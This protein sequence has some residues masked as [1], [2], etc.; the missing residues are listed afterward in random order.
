MQSEKGAVFR[1][2]EYLLSDAEL[3]DQGLV[4]PLCTCVLV[5][6]VD[7]PCC[8]Q[9]FCEVC[10][11]QL[12][13]TCPLCRATLHGMSVPSS[14]VVQQV[15]DKLKLQCPG[16][17]KKQL[18]RSQL[19][20]HLAAE[21][22]GARVSR[23]REEKLRCAGAPVCDA[24]FDSEADKRAHERRCVAAYV[25]G[26]V[27]ELRERC[28]RLEDT[29]RRL[30]LICREM[31]N[32]NSYTTTSEN[33]SRAVCALPMGSHSVLLG[34]DSGLWQVD[35]RTGEFVQKD[36]KLR[37]VRVI[38]QTGRTLHVVSRDGWC[39]LDAS[40]AQWGA[41]CPPPVLAKEPIL[42]RTLVA[43]ASLDQTYAFVLTETGEAFY[44]MNN[45]VKLLNTMWAEKAPRMMV[46][47]AEG[48]FV[49][50]VPQVG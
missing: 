6:P 46:A 35:C 24:V 40:A 26:E 44:F 4:C 31:R 16:G 34:L 8:R 18:D 10:F 17:C 5:E 43:A 48:E 14:R 1:T 13:G 27:G 15:L 19:L 7:S 37:N 12:K 41:A 33:W 21:H 36:V 3:E 9:T 47:V 39:T 20:S 22:G 38:V 45:A 23:V 49:V 30:K 29:N 11:A 25:K 32:R 42:A 50:V 28:A 2:C